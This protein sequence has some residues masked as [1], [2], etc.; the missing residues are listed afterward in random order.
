MN[1]VGPLKRKSRLASGRGHKRYQITVALSFDNIYVHESL[2]VTDLDHLFC[3]FV[4][5]PGLIS[6]SYPYARDHYSRLLV[7]QA[8]TCLSAAEKTQLSVLAAERAQK[9]GYLQFEVVWHHHSTFI[10]A[11]SLQAHERIG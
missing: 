2:V 10:L 3:P 4:R 9:D 6:I 8:P 11:V 7:T 1:V 5:L